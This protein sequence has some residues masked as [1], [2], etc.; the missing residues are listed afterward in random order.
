MRK[1]WVELPGV[2]RTV[3]MLQV[4]IAPGGSK[5]LP[6]AVDLRCHSRAAGQLKPTVRAPDSV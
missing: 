4:S 6:A 2:A 5:Q 3:H 1:R